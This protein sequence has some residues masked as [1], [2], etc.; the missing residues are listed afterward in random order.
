MTLKCSHTAPAHAP[1]ESKTCGTLDFLTMDTEVL[2]AQRRRLAARQ[3]TA[4]VNLSA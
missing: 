4:T 1:S 2:A 3:L